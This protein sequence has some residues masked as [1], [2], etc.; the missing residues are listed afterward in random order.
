VLATILVDNCI[1]Q[2]EYTDVLGGLNPR[3]TASKA[4]AAKSQACT[5]VSCH[6]LQ[7]G[8]TLPAVLSHVDLEQGRVFLSF[9][10]ATPNPLQQTLDSMLGLSTSAAAAAAYARRRTADSLNGT[11]GGWYTGESSSSS[12]GAG[13]YGSQ[14]ST[15]MEGA[16]GGATSSV[17]ESQVDL[18]ARLGDMEGAL[19]FCEA[20]R[21]SPG[22]EDAQPGVRLQS[23]AASQAF[24]VRD[25][26]WAAR[27]LILLACSVGLRFHWCAIGL[28]LCGLA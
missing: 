11:T 7:V 5:S 9:R 12:G 10:L 8:Q 1:S 6:P 24:E 17:E 18:R 4:Q 20:L 28:R 2:W 25:T 14:M 26:C 27:V 15:S 3:C 23:R 22:V 21:R 13:S 19:R 16:T